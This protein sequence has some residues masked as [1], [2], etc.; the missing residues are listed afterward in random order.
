MSIGS[1]GVRRSRSD[2]TIVEKMRAESRKQLDRYRHDLTT[3]PD[4]RLGDSIV[5][6]F[7]ILDEEHFALEQEISVCMHFQNTEWTGKRNSHPHLWHFIN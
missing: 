5:R 6:D 3:S 7:F 2:P 4:V 1:R